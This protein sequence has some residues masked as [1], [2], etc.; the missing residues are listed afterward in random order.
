MKYRAEIDG[1][2]ALSVISIIF[3]HAGFKLFSGGYIG[4]DV[5]FVISG[6]LITSIILT[7][8]G[9]NDFSLINFYERRARRILPALFLVMIVSLIFA[10]FYYL[11]SELKVFGLNLAAAAIF[12]A[13]IY[14]YL[15]EGDYFGIHS[16]YNPILH[17][18]SLAVEEQ[19]YI[20]YPLALLATLHFKEKFAIIFMAVLALIS[21]IF[22]QYLSTYNPLLNFYLLP[23]RAWELLIGAFI[24]FYHAN[25]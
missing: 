3:Y 10:W 15:F 1:L 19:F 6:Y 5:F 24:A 16:E 7:E 9:T 20:F 22:S 21:F 11:P 23:T 18:W 8:K 13:N 12:L 17:L 2:R 4:V 25:Q 14:T